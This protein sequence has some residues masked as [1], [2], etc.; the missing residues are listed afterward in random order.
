MNITERNT[1]DITNAPLQTLA[2]GSMFWRPDIQAVSP[3]LYH[4]P[5]LFW[6][7]EALRP[8]R[9]V[10]LGS[11]HGAPHYALCQGCMR[12]G[13]TSECI[14]VD[15]TGSGA[16]IHQQ[17]ERQYGSVSQHINSRLRGAAKLV[18]KK[19]IDILIL[20]VHH[21]KEDD[22]EDL[23]DRWLP[24][25]SERGVILIPAIGSPSKKNECHRAFT[26]LSESYPAFSFSQGKGL[27]VLMVGSQPSQMLSSWLERWKSPN[28][29]TM[30]EDVFGRLGRACMDEAL[31]KQQKAELEKQRQTI[32]EGLTVIEEA[33][34]RNDKLESSIVERDHLLSEAKIRSEYAEKATLANQTRA[35]SLQ[36]KLSEVTL[37]LRLIE[38]EQSKKSKAVNNKELMDI[39]QRLNESNAQVIELMALV[40]QQ[41]SELNDAMDSLSHAVEFTETSSSEKEQ[42]INELNLR[43]EQQK[44]ELADMM[45]SLTQ[46]AEYAESSIK[47]KDQLR[48]QLR[49]AQ[50]ALQQQTKVSEK[51]TKKHADKIAEL[52]SLVEKKGR[53]NKKLVQKVSALEDESSKRND[54]VSKKLLL[55]KEVE[56]LK[57]EFSAHEQALRDVNIKHSAEVVELNKKIL[58]LTRNSAKAD[59]LESKVS[60][61][62]SM[63]QARD[64][65][66]NTQFEQ[67]EN[68]ATSQE[69]DEEVP[70]QSSS[71]EG[72]VS[73]QDAP[74][75]IV[76]PVETQRPAT[77]PHQEPIKSSR[78]GAGRLFGG[79][80]EKDKRRARRQQ[81]LEKEQALAEI[82]QSVL[83]DKEWYLQQYPD[84]AGSSDF[85]KNPAL[86]YLKFGGFEARDPSPDFDSE[87][88]LRAYPDVAASEL[89]PLL[90]YLRFGKDEGRSPRPY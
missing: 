75:D 19:S 30:V 87:S 67:L 8:E 72:I 21:K 22:I 63:I 54:D 74:T 39:Q 4:L 10:T 6:L 45:D 24:R 62:E 25:M 73:S 70:S 65:I 17:A 1:T 37:Q 56:V 27:G 90:H 33:N 16:A 61:L 11:L 77:S 44:T 14:L 42:Q 32:V 36:E 86:H 78:F 31:V 66:I 82:E 20:D 57:Q 18:E 59:E 81:R 60:E 84:V 88:Y 76:T 26:V 40:E 68:V 28:T 55:E 53:E 7:V 3:W 48:N 71:S 5:W 13:L 46:S 47:E 51:E 12:L 83:F 2:Q 49:S 69:E 35:E 38:Q 64:E 50:D 29:A 43:V 23:I 41:K 9:C 85:A 80:G 58:E 79:S 15:D 89:N 34:A 52:Q